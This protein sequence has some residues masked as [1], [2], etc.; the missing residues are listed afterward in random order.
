MSNLRQCLRTIQ[1]SDSTHPG[2]WVDKYLPDNEDGRKQE[3]VAKVSGI[4]VPDTYS[5]YYGRW[6]SALAGN[7][8]IVTRR[9]TVQGRLSVGLGGEGVL[10]TA[11]TLHRTYGVPYIPG[12]A[13]KGLAA[14]YARNKL[15][16]Q[17]WGKESTA[18]RTMFGDTKSAGYV[19]FFDALYVP[20]TG[21]GGKP[22]WP[23]VITVHHPNYYQGNEP[24]AD[25]DSP[26][27][28]AFLSATGAYLL[29]ISGPTAWVEKAYEILALALQEEGVGAKT[30]SGYG[31]MSIEGMAGPAMIAGAPMP[32]P[33]TTD[34]EQAIVDQFLLQLQNLSDAN[35]PSQIPTIAQRWQTLE[36]SRDNKL[37]IAEAILAKVKSTG[38]TKKVQDKPW[39]EQLRGYVEEG[40]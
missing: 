9:A 34:P 2:L 26:T 1:C 22:L 17:D 18:Y 14:N 15:S 19:T 16:E 23:D 32:A 37:R 27:P 8:S 36:L 21:H 30:S 40:G 4:A 24:P 7:G 31:R 11:I 10:E 12:S 13:L 25:W 33:A 28:V 39:F 5:Q 3:L 29:A 38:R 20:G 35:A 6:R